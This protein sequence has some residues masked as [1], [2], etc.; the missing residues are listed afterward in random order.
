MLTEVA[1]VEVQLSVEESPLAMEE[2]FALSVTV[3]AAGGGGGGAVTGGGAF[4]GFLQPKAKMAATAAVSSTARRNEREAKVMRCPPQTVKIIRRAHK[5]HPTGKRHRITGGLGATIHRNTIYCAIRH[6][7]SMR[8]IQ[9]CFQVFIGWTNW[10]IR[11]GR[12]W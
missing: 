2:G 10:A 1:F 12:R 3:G 4:G 5:S 9:L 11:Y 8:E 7:G 6:T